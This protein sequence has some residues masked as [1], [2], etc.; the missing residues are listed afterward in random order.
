MM[1]GTDGGIGRL[2]C[3]P[4]GDT[5]PLASLPLKLPDP[6]PLLMVVSSLNHRKCEYRTRPR[7]RCQIKLRAQAAIRPA[8]PGET[9][10]GSG[11]RGDRHT[12]RGAPGGYATAGTVQARRPT[13][14]DPADSPGPNA[15]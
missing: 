8:A 15:P 4:R 10:T 6:L 11:V 3:G 2:T 7:A 1:R 14:A 13:P 9:A 12:R 5:P